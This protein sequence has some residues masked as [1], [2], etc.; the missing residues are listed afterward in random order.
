ML[1]KRTLVQKNN[2]C[3]EMHNT[4]LLNEASLIESLIN[5]SLYPCSSIN[6]VF[7]DYEMLI[8]Y[9]RYCMH[10]FAVFSSIYHVCMCVFED[11]IENLLNQNT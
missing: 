9:R 5:R 3:T 8:L 10:Y 1:L 11:I 4:E 7:R 6:V 2:K